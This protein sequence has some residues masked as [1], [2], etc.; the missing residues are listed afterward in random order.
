MAPYLNLHQKFGGRVVLLAAA[1]FLQAGLSIAVL[2]FTTLV[3]TATDFGNYA[4][5]MSLAIF[6]NAMGDGGGAL[7]L[8]AHYSAITHLERRR[9]LGSFFLVSLALSSAIAI[10]F[11]AAWPVLAGLIFNDQASGVSWTMTII[12]ALLVPLRSVSAIALTVFSV[13]GRGLSIAGQIAVQAVL[14]F[15]GTTVSLFA[16]HLGP[17]ALFVGA[18]CGQVGSLAT[19]LVLLGSEPWGRPS[20]KWLRVVKENAPVAAFSGVADGIRSISENALVVTNLSV[21]TLGYYSHARLYYSMLVS[22]TNAI[23]HN[24][25]STSLSEARATE[26]KFTETRMIWTLAYIMLTVFG[27]GS[28]GLGNEFVGLLTNDRLTPAAW[29][30]P[31]LAILLIVNLSGR[32][33][34]AVVYAHGKAADASRARSIISLTILAMLPF[35]IGQFYGVGLR[36]GLAGLI[37]AL[38]LE[39][40]AFRSYIRYKA[41]T[42]DARVTFHDHWAVGGIIAIALAWLA[43]TVFHPGI[44]FRLVW[45]GAAFV[46]IAALE[47]ARLAK[48]L[49]SLQKVFKNPGQ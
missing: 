40:A 7:A 3:L 41:H 14:T 48:L 16:F 38:L 29:M 39:A 1:T 43:N 10:L 12:T 11:L 23:T 31:W 49:V 2:P 21:M 22:V 9:M 6:A 34:I 42:I 15:L 17:E 36:L 18:L 5:M 46:V 13:S 28:V 47:K 4:L 19:S 37:G 20:L 26:L 25:W 32:A 33:Q 45:I 30:I 35:L 27:I 44:A 24:I 8:P